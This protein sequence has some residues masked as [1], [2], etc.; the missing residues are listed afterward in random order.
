MGALC[1]MSAIIV[2]AP[3]NLFAAT[4]AAEAGK[5]IATDR[6]EMKYDVYAGGFHVVAADL[7]VD[8]QKKSNYRL[9]L[10]AHTRGFLA[11]L[12]PWEG[13]FETK[14]WY[15]SKA[16]QPQPEMHSSNTTF[17]EDKEVVEFVYNKNGSFK[18]Y[19]I[20]NDKKNGVQ[21][22]QTE[23]SDNTTDVLSATL[24]VMN[25]IT[26]TGKCEGMDKI[27]DGS[28]SY[29]LVYQHQGHEIL[30]ANDFN[31]YSGPSIFCTVEVKPLKGKWHEKPRG[32]MSIQEQGRERGT[33]PTVWFAQMAPGEPAVPVKIRVKTEYGALM[34][35]LTHYKGPSKTLNLPE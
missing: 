19:R 16:A 18:E 8:L 30:K 21:P 25:H 3:S 32:W 6:Q 31:V 24:E 28:R 22:P 20:F 12:A 34:M 17:R 13:V 26:Q 23:L 33:M 11:K 1:A 4:N 2:S 10:G 9:R 35:H 15:D 7:L 29:D 27:F 14:G 5:K